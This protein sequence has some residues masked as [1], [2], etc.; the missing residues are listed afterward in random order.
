MSIDFEKLWTAS[1]VLLPEDD[2]M[3]R[4]L[5]R[6]LEVELAPLIAW[7]SAADGRLSH[8][9]LEIYRYGNYYRKIKAIEVFRRE[10]LVAQPTTIGFLYGRSVQVAPS[11]LA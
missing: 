9:E 7:S 3:L 1:M 8:S 10:L 6:C 4:P 5:L 2:M 11:G